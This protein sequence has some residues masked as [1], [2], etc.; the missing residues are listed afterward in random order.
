MKVKL[1]FIVVVYSAKQ[2][3]NV[4]SKHKTNL[5]LLLR[6]SKLTQSNSPWD[7]ATTQKCTFVV[8]FFSQQVV[9]WNKQ[10]NGIRRLGLTSAPYKCEG[11][12]KCLCDLIIHT[13]I[14]TATLLLHFFDQLFTCKIQWFTDDISARVPDAKHVNR[15]AQRRKLGGNN[16]DGQCVARGN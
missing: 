10:G 7:Y 8:P 2:W 13:I 11:A 4:I 1:H 3:N 12:N 16:S 15:L 9:V 5:W 14:F 6:C